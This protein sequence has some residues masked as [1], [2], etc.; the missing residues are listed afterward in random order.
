MTW[1]IDS[2]F[3]NGLISFQ[4]EVSRKMVLDPIL[5]TATDHR[6]RNVYTPAT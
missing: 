3:T 2:I 6:T 4:V 5:S 1:Y